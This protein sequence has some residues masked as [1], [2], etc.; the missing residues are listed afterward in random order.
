MRIAPEGYR[1]IAGSSAVLAA[2]SALCW[3]GFPWGIAGCAVVWIWVISFF[4]DPHRSTDYQPDRL[5]APADGTVADITTV[6]SA[7]GFSGSVLRIGIFL[8]IF[9]VHI[10]RSPMAGTIRSLHYRPGAF[11][12][13]RHPQAGE[14]NESN[15]LIMEPSGALIGPVVVRQVAG[16]IARRIICHARIGDTLTAGQRFGLIKFGSRT[17]LIVPADQYVAR[18]EVGQ[19][20]RGGLTVLAQA[21]A[22]ISK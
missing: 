20:V 19:T 16:K 2:L 17:E 4:R 5:Y 15:T 7:D 22:E 12:D 1:E 8:S 9:N 11:L 14:R 18:V 10:N 6:A 13:A 21:R 3:F